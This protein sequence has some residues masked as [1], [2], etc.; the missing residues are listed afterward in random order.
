MSVVDYRIAYHARASSFRSQC[1]YFGRQVERWLD[2][3][4][5]SGR[6]HPESRLAFLSSFLWDG[7][8]AFIRGVVGYPPFMVSDSDVS[9]QEEE[10]DSD[11]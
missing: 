9:E 4:V 1:H 11:E 8:L 10:S 5:S 6:I 7:V 2:E 3:E